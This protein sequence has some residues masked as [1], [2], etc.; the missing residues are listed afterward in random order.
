MTQEEMN[1]LVP[2]KLKEIER[3]YN[4]NVLWAVES[5]SRAWGF[6]SPDSDFDVRFI[7]KR[8]PKDYL[9][10]NPQ[11]DVIELPVDEIWDLNGWDL[12]KTLT[13][14]QKSNPTLYEWMNSPVRYYC[15]DFVKRI[16][17]LLDECFSEEKMLYHYLCTAKND[18]KAHLQGETIKPKKYFYSLRSVLACMWIMNTH[19]APPVPF[20]SL[21]EAVLPAELKP[22]VDYLLKL[23]LNSPEKAEIK[24]IEEIDSFLRRKTEEIEAYLGAL[25]NIKGAEWDNL[26]E[27]FWNEIN[28]D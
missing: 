17:P 2:I 9:K 8:K 5:G 22:S 19:S 18:A 16:R 7:Y 13:L 28:L 20:D 6:A 11:R 25:R 23:K 15:T 14:L 27:F 26:N 3:E 12:D 24:H 10:L 21:T 1:V 4:V